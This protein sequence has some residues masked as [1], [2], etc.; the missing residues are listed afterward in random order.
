M[1]HQYHDIHDTEFEKLVLLICKEILGQGVQGFTKGADGGKDGK[2]IGTANLYPSQAS[3]WNGHTIIQAKH[4]M[5]INKH[6]LQS[7]FFSEKSNNCIVA[8][9][10]RKL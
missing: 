2:F 3:P 10:A 9:E 7:D 6:Y 5:G 8:E 4:T 1:M